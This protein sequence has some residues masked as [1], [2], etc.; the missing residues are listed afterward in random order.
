MRLVTHICG[1]G[2]GKA[3][4]VREPNSNARQTQIARLPVNSLPA[5][6]QEAER[7]LI[8]S[9]FVLIYEPHQAPLAAY[10]W[11]LKASFVF[12]VP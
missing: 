12:F 4:A 1:E 2:K 8:E 9:T 11:P 5:V 6:L 7:V 3:A 10:L